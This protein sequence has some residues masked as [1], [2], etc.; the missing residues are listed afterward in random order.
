MDV[1]AQMGSDTAEGEEELVPF[2]C[3]LVRAGSPKMREYSLIFPNAVYTHTH[4]YKCIA[5]YFLIVLAG[6]FQLDTP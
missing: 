4:I 3:K 1:P 5:A 6:S 2:A